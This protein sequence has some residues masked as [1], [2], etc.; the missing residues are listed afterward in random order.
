[1]KSA[2]I[3]VALIA[4]MAFAGSPANAA[5]PHADAAAPELVSVSAGAYV[6]DNITWE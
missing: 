1:L 2:L 5:R 4:A 3:S 6:P